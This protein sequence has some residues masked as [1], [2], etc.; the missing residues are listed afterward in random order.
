MRS[1]AGVI[2]AVSALSSVGC[3]VFATKGPEP[4]RRPPPPCTTS[5]AP[6]IVDTVVAVAA[7][8]IAIVGGLENKGHCLVPESV[9]P[10]VDFTCGHQTG[11]ATMT[12]VFFTA[13][14][15]AGFVE[16]SACRDSLEQG[17]RP[18]VSSPL[19]QSSSRLASPPACPARGDAPRLCSFDAYGR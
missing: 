5:Y 4:W 6:P 15:I 17:A 11:F 16:T 18:P 8:S 10:F 19:P 2:I 13:S 9:P 7:A 12:S 14:A 1:S 3:S